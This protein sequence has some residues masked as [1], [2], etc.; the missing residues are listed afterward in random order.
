MLPAAGTDDETIDQRWRD[1]LSTNLDGVYYVTRAVL[2]HVPNEDGRIIN[3]SSVLGR[4]GVPG[5][6]AYCTTKHGIIGFTRA[7]ALELA[8]R[9]ITVNAVCPGWVSTEMAWK[10]M[11]DTA[12]NLGITFEEFRAQA[13]AGVPL[14]RMIEPRK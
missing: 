11:R 1:I 9:R 3:I 4:F 8:S 14:G 5:Y 7:L 13:M 2:P 6:A 12:A 10:G